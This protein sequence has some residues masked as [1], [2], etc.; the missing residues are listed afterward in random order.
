MSRIHY[1]RQNST[2]LIHCWLVLG[3]I[4]DELQI[5]R[6]EI[7]DTNFLQLTSSFHLFKYLPCFLEIRGMYDM[8]VVYQE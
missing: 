8:R 4:E 6:T 1:I 5:L 2:Y 7:A 3:S